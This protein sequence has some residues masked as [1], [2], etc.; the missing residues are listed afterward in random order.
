MSP[1]RDRPDPPSGGGKQEISAAAERGRDRVRKQFQELRVEIEELQAQEG[2]GDDRVAGGFWTAARTSAALLALSAAIAAAAVNFGLNGARSPKEGSITVP[3][4]PGQ[5]QPGVI[6]VGGESSATPPT[7]LSRIAPG[8]QIGTFAALPGAGLPSQGPSTQLVVA[9]TAPVGAHRSPR[10][11]VASA[12]PVSQAPTPTPSAPL[13]EAPQDPPS[14]PLATTGDDGDGGGK[15]PPKDVTTAA[16]PDR[17]DEGLQ[18]KDHGKGHGKGHAGSPGKGHAGSPGKGHAE[19]P[20]KGHA[21][22][23]GKGHAESPGKGHAES[24]GKGHEKDEGGEAPAP[25]TPSYPGPPEGGPG[26]GGK[27]K[28]G[29]KGKSS[30]PGRGK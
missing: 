29:G 17:D 14:S 20:G 22:S 24:P 28:D 30:A 5:P 26:H 15:K 21:E 6:G 4:R 10:Q 19:S 12:D 9:E 13:A 7:F 2:G 16:R 3:P 27:G 23:P 25:V 1:P 18:G 11:E 8:L